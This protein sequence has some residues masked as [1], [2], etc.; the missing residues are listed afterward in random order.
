MKKNP[1]KQ[2]MG[3]KKTPVKNKNMVARYFCFTILNSRTLSEISSFIDQ[4]YDLRIL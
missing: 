1:Y 3:K 2:Q 4:K